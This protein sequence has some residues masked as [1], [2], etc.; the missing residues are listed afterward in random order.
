MFYHAAGCTISEAAAGG[1]DRPSEATKSAMPTAAASRRAAR[2]TAD[3][4]RRSRSAP[5]FPRVAA[6][7]RKKS[8]PASKGTAA[9]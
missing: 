4:T 6:A 7:I 5:L 2:T 1:D 8:T 3:E 9:V